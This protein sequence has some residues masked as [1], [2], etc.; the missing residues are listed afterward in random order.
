MRMHPADNGCGDQGLDGATPNV[1][2]P[3]KPVPLLPQADRV[4]ACP[5]DTPAQRARHPHKPLPRVARPLRTRRLGSSPS[6][7]DRSILRA[8]FLGQA[9]VRVSVFQIPA[10]CLAAAAQPSLRVPDFGGCFQALLVV[11]AFKKKSPRN[12]VLWVVPGLEE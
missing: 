1:R 8:V 11:W 5:K 7:A 9:N 12:A 6:H 2:L 4:L 3:G 10:S